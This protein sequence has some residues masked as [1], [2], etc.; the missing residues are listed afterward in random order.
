MK[1][2]KE[3]I[4]AATTSLNVWSNRPTKICDEKGNSNLGHYFS[5]Y[6]LFELCV[7]DYDGDTKLVYKGKSKKDLWNYIKSL[8][9][10]AKEVENV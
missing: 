1:I 10:K 2:N 5:L 3:E 6:R 8:I 9:E 4:L 7:I